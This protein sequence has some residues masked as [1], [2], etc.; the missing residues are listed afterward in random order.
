[1]SSSNFWQ[2]LHRCRC[3][4]HIKDEHFF[5]VLSVILRLLL[6]TPIFENIKILPSILFMYYKFRMAYWRIN[7]FLKRR[8]LNTLPLHVFS[9]NFLGCKSFVFYWKLDLKKKC[10]KDFEQFT[11]NYRLEQADRTFET[12][13]YANSF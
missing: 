3:Q 5:H 12:I 13:V 8:D 1:M 10:V 11:C 9:S 6:P 4:L 7:Y 2:F